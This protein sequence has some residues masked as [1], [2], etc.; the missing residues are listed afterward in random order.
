VPLKRTTRATIQ[1]ANKGSSSFHTLKTVTTKS[2][3]TWTFTST[4]PKGRAWRVVWTDADGTKFTGPRTLA[5][6][7][8]RLQTTK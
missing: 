3:G 6:A 2:D 7:D 4:N 8:P 5:Y 1:Y